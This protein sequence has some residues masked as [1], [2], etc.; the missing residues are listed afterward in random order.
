MILGYQFHS[1]GLQLF[2]ARL[3]RALD[4]SRGILQ[5]RIVAFAIPQ[6]QPFFGKRFEEL[7]VERN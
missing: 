6:R 7:R 2:V 5:F 4:G 1:A 3:P